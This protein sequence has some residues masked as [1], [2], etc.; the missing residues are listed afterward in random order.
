M[1]VLLLDGD[2]LPLRNPETLFESPE[3]KTLGNLFFPDF[4]TGVMDLLQEMPMTSPENI[5]QTIR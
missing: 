1:Q 2:N 5:A 4:W 3:Y